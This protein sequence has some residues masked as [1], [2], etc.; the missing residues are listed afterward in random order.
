MFPG[1][2]GASPLW[3]CPWLNVNGWSLSPYSG[4]GVPSSVSKAPTLNSIGPAPTAVSAKPVMAVAVVAICHEFMP[5]I[6]ANVFSWGAS[7][8]TVTWAPAV[9]SIATSTVT[10]PTPCS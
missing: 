10:P 3:P 5:T 2:A 6:F 8:S 1:P 4:S 9:V 7:M